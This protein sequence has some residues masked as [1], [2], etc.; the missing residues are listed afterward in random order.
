MRLPHVRFTVRRLMVAVAFVAATSL[1]LEMNQRAALYRATASHHATLSREWLGI[2]SR[3]R[4]DEALLTGAPGREAEA[5]AGWL[6]R[7]APYHDSLMRKWARAS[8]YPWLPVA[9]DPPEPE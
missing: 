1:L 2:A 9:P 6:E 7:M 5:T 4:S 8:Q 3:L